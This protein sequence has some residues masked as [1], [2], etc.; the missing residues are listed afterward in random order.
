MSVFRG[1]ENGVSEIEAKLGP[2]KLL[3]HGAF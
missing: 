1:D 2:K 3:E